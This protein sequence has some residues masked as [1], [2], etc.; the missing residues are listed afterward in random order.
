MY[1]NIKTKVV[2]VFKA[3]RDMD[4]QKGLLVKCNYKI[5]KCAME[6]R[7]S[8]RYFARPLVLYLT[9]DVMY[10]ILKS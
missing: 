8:K 1:K 5:G 2:N 10:S 3:L 9:Y 4:P 7:K 6:K